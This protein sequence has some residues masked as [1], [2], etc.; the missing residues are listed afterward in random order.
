M[1]GRRVDRVRWVPGPDADTGVPVGTGNTV[2]DSP[3]DRD[4][5]PANGRPSRNGT[6]LS[7]QAP[8]G[9]HTGATRYQPGQGS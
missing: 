6:P 9:V 2:A 1:D 4:N 5:A 8:A 7:T 3:L